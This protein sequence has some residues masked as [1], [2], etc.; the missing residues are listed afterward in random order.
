[1]I[2]GPVY[3]G[4]IYISESP[5]LCCFLPLTS[6]W[7]ILIHSRHTDPIVKGLFLA[8]DNKTNMKGLH[9]TDN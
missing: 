8:T 6:L 4:L 1:M 7:H 2:S 3:S 9:I 5:T